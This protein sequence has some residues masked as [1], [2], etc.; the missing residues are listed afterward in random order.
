MKP[1]AQVAL[2]FAAFLCGPLARD[3]ASGDERRPEYGRV[4]FNVY[5]V[6]PEIP[7]EFYTGG[8]L[9]DVMVV[10]VAGAHAVTNEYTRLIACRWSDG[11]AVVLDDE[12][13][14]LRAG[15]STADCSQKWLDAVRKMPGLAPQDGNLVH[16][17]NTLR[18]YVRLQN[19][20]LLYSIPC[21]SPKVRD[22]APCLKNG[23]SWQG[24]FDDLACEVSLNPA[25]FEG[26]L[27]S[28]RMCRVRNE[29]DSSPMGRWLPWPIG[30]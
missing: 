8:T 12:T 18:F 6:P 23:R 4:K 26:F 29:L 10:W 20:Y 21:D 2:F 7:A 11:G 1:R 15:H 13:G 17:L 16:Q 24:A 9:V 25:P 19:S 30:W 5:Y 27:D 3:V 28:N 22:L 14:V